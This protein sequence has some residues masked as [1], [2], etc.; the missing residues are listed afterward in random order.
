MLQMFGDDFT[1]RAGAYEK[2]HGLA[3][4]ESEYFDERNV[5]KLATLEGFQLVENAYVFRDK[6][7]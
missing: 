2:K 5:R 7:Y 6:P 3:K 4:L 1:E